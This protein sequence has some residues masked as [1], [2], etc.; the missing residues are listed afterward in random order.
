M[1]EM[2][3]D[4]ALLR[5]EARKE[6]FYE[7]CTLDFRVSLL[8]LKME[9]KNMQLLSICFTSLLLMPVTFY[10]AHKTK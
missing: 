4:G 10:F 7:G 6:N 3:A 9:R 1:S 5:R 8:L 2:N